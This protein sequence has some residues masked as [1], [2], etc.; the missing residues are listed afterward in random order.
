VK[1][2][3]RGAYS[4]ERRVV[5]LRIEGIKEDTSYNGDFMLKGQ[6]GRL[7]Q[8]LGAVGLDLHQ[9]RENTQ[10]FAGE[11]HVRTKPNS[12]RLTALLMDASEKERE[13]KA[14]FSPFRL[15]AG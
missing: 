13:H 8:K 10:I 9:L 11:L 3:L 4:D 2:L 12:I 7:A 15:W 5:V 1:L 6:S 14:P